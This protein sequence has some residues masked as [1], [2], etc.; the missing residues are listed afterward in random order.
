MCI[1]RKLNALQRKSIKQRLGKCGHTFC[2]TCL[3]SWFQQSIANA[4]GNYGD[5]TIPEYLKNPLY[6]V[7]DI[8]TIFMC[9]YVST[10]I[11]DKPTETQ[12]LWELIEGINSAFGSPEEP[13]DDNSIQFLQD[14]W[15]DCWFDKC[16]L[17]TIDD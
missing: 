9:K 17:I 10:C 1:N 6:S 11:M 14:I 16:E 4:M 2:H 7:G 8:N 15:A 13:T 3:W 12:T 5:I